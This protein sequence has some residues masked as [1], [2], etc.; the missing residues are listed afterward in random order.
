VTIANGTE[1]E[2]FTIPYFLASKWEA[3]KSRGALDFRSSS[4]FEDIV[5][6]LENAENI[7]E[8]LINSPPEVK[9]YLKQKFA[10]WVD[11]YEFEEGL[12]CHVERGS[13]SDKVP[14][15]I[16]MLRQIFMY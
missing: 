8:E 2:I 11:R 9:S 6:V 10:E 3:F 16:A 12:Y 1:I 15:I 5:Y 4:D 7:E 13:S 14:A